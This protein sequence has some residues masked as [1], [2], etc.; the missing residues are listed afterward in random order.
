M[1]V[2]MPLDQL[3]SYTGS[4][5]EPAD[6]DAFW[7]TTLDEART[8]RRDP[9][10]EPV[11]HPFA[12]VDIYDVSFSGWGGEPIRGWLR[13]PKDPSEPVPGIAVCQGYGGGRGFAFE[14][15]MWAEAGYAILN[16]DTRGQGATWGNGDTP[17]NGPG[18][19]PQYPG[20]MTRGIQDPNKHFYRRLM[21][22][23][24][25]GFEMLRALP[26]VD[27]ERVGVTGGSQGGGLSLAVTA[28][29]EGVRASYP[30]V[31]FL[32]DYRRATAITDEFPFREISKYIA[33][34]RLEEE[35]VYRTLSYFDGVNF[36]RRATAPV[37][38]TAAL[39]DA[40]V[41]ASTIFAAYN[42][43]AGS[44]KDIQVW[45]HNGHEGGEMYDEFDKFHFFA[46]HLGGRDF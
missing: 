29:A 43:Y 23:C 12:H 46:K 34:H 9:I 1:L 42:N 31:P 32:C 14:Q 6:F 38:M 37:K 17:D 44:T 22:D 18:A 30:L 45:S 24:V 39:M 3:R 28:L 21:T 40:T 35:Q 10:L 19:G 27:A 11:A 2:D 15:L 4:S 33:T 26:F 25:L 16:I 7:A 8:L 5:E 20:W 36:A 13:T 41:P